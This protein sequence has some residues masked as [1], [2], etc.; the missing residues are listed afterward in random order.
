[1][2]ALRT[3]ADILSLSIEVCK[4][5][6]ADLCNLDCYCWDGDACFG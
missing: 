6:I 4:V 2:S 5:P 3:K 1:M